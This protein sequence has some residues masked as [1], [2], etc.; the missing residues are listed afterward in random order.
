M[1]CHYCDEEVRDAALVCRYCGQN[2]SVTAPLSRRI[3]ELEAEVSELRA[4]NIELLQKDDELQAFRIRRAQSLAW[5]NEPTPSTIR[6]AR[7]AAVLV[8]AVIAVLQRWDLR[9]HPSVDDLSWQF[10]AIVVLGV[11]W[12]LISLISGFIVGLRLPGRRLRRYTIDGIVF[13]G[14]A[15]TFISLGF[16]STI[17]DVESMIFALIAGGTVLLLSLTG[18]LVGDLTKRIIG[19]EP[20]RPVRL[21]FADEFA[22]R[23]VG[24]SPAQT[25]GT[26]IL[27]IGQILQAFAPLLTF[28]GA[29]LGG[30]ITYISRPK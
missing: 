6:T 2:L 16:L 22:G 3:T 13:A 4:E 18:A 11:V 8:G 29:L 20:A 19:G 28:A 24:Y 14:I 10:W 17:Y 1:R 26:E 21:R 15:I 5:K 23:G 9:E 27:R 12:G 25:D 30:Y 7:I